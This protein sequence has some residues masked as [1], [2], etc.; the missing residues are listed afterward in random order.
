MKE[1]FQYEEALTGWTADIL[2]DRN[3][4]LYKN[5]QIIHPGFPF[6]ND[7]NKKHPYEVF[8]SQF[9]AHYA[10]SPRIA[11]IMAHKDTQIVQIPKDIPNMVVEYPKSLELLSKPIIHHPSQSKHLAED[12]YGF[13][14]VILSSL[15][16]NKKT[17]GLHA[18]LSNL[19]P[20]YRKIIDDVSL[21]EIP[22]IEIYKIVYGMA[23]MHHQEGDKGY[24][25]PQN[26][27]VAPGVVHSMESGSKGA[28]FALVMR[29]ARL[30]SPELRHI[31]FTQ[32]QAA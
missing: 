21:S 9:V 13:D 32:L 16:P 19:D 2:D 27:W 15:G 11:E 7:G 29:Y 3:E 10:N 8:L 1:E 25:V 28:I 23:I 14:T 12:Q 31:R 20:E 4:P 17:A 18:H 22:A 6:P 30:Y 26:F 5:G 24:V